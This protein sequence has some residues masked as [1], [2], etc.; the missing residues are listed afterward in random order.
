MD[1]CSQRHP[2]IKG[3][4]T[5]LCLMILGACV[6]PV[7]P[8]HAPPAWEMPAQKESAPHGSSSYSHSVRWPTET[9]SLIARWY[10][11]SASSWRKIA[12]YNPSLDPNRLAIGDVVAIPMSM[13]TTRR[14]MPRTFLPAPARPVRRPPSPP[15]AEELFGPMDAP[16][17]IDDADNDLFPPMN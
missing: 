15:P 12:R 14:P 4:L 10:T 2:I 9:L 3:L 11:G 13:M 8:D 1:K 6:H 5:L 7:P 17:L 16:P